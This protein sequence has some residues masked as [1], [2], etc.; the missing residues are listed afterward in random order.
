MKVL[1]LV[2]IPHISTFTSLANTA[3]THPRGQQ[4]LAKNRQQYF[5]P[6]ASPRV[7]PESL[8]MTHRD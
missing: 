1:A 6:M 7:Y 5:V 4:P 3:Q 8:A 2:S